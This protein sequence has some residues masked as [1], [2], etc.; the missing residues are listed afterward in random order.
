MKSNIFKNIAKNQAVL[1]VFIFLFIIFS[2]FVPAFFSTRN[3]INILKQTSILGIVACGLTFSVIAGNVDLS[4][5]SIVSLSG[6]L[7][8]SFSYR[9]IWLAILV[10]ILAAILIGLFNGFIITR[11]NSNSVIITLASLAVIRGLALIYTGGK[12]VE[13]ADKSKF[14]L[15][16]RSSIGG[17][18]AYVFGFLAIALILGI[19]INYTSLG[20]FVY[21]SGS[22][23]DASRIAG[24]KVDN[25]RIYTFIISAVFAAIAGI[26]LSSR[27]YTASP[28]TGNGY[29]FDAVAAIVV[30][31]N[32]LLGGKGNIYRTV[33]GIFFIVMVI[34][35]MIL[36]N[37]PVAFQYIAKAVIIIVA[38][39]LDIRT[40][41]VNI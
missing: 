7:A 29:E 10:P 30:G 21:H 31:G 35:A 15:V 16:G 24:I 3:L 33:I 2:I 12:M 41:R 20:R 39:W 17:I 36:L 4:V 14:I 1:I 32:S 40:S 18:P 28:L 38:V 6:V 26:I 27:L 9:S 13:G 25:I 23:I 11:F 19:I 34:N 5:G 37:L 22:N 8:L